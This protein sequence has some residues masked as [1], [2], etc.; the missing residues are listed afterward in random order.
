MGKKRGVFRR[1]E[2]GRG[3]RLLFY[4]VREE[5]Q[6]EARETKIPLST[7]CADS[8]TSIRDAK[9]KSAMG[10]FSAKSLFGVGRDLFSVLRKFFRLA[11]QRLFVSL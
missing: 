11:E 3:K 4:G 6:I 1:C 10:A 7:R 5:K 8:L 9:I 2:K